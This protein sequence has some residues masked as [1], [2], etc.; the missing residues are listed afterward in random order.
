MW[1]LRAFRFILHIVL[2]LLIVLAVFPLINEASRIN[3]ERWYS[4]KLISLFRITPV[5]K[6]TWPDMPGMLV[7]NHVSWLDIFAVNSHSPS[8]FIAK[9]EIASWPLAGRLVSAAGTLFIERGR[10]QAVHKV[11][12]D[13]EARMRSGR[14]VAVCPE[15]TTTDGSGLAVF[16]ANMFQAA[17][18]AQLPLIPMALRYTDESGALSTDPAFVGEQTMLQNVMVLW[19]SSKRYTVTLVPCEPLYHPEWTRHQYANAC[20]DAILRRL[21]ELAG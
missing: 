5:L 3:L 12:K 18:N 10:R 17:V 8:I 1:L 4:R 16:H 15:G 9:S 11:I 6:G 2:G 14:Q 13:A 19:R 7:L 20:R 21:D